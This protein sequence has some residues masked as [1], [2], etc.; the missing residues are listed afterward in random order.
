MPSK[1]L[2]SGRIVGTHGVRGEVRVDPWCDEPKFLTRFK[3]LY[4]DKFGDAV[5]NVKT[6]RVHGN[7]CLFKI[8]GVDSIEDAEKLRG[9]VIY[10]DRDDCKLP[11]GSY[12]V[13]DIIGCRVLN[14]DCD[15]QLGVIT[16][17]S[18]TGANDVWHIKYNDK[19]YLIPNVPEIVKKVDIAEQTVFITPLKGTFDDED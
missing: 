11:K 18:Q 9:R 13:T 10:I 14:A 1:F 12:F 2:E 8:D 7:I 17:V 5:L 19:E 15:E 4:L 16:D 6:S 3:K